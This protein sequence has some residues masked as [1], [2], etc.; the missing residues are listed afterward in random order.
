MSKMV[1]RSALA[2]GVTWVVNT[3][4]VTVEG[5]GGVTDH[6]ALTGLADDDHPQYAR[7]AQNLA[8]LASAATAR[9]NLGLGTAAVAAA[10]DFDA[11]GAAAAAQAAAIA[12][13]QPVDSDLTAISVLTTTS[14]GRSL[15]TQAD[16]PAARST[17]GV[18]RVVGGQDVGPRVEN[19]N[20]ETRI[21]DGTI[22]L[23]ALAAGE[24]VMFRGA[25]L[26]LNNSG[27]TR[28]VTLRLKVGATTLCRVVSGTLGSS[29]VARSG[30]IDGY[31][32]ANGNNDADGEMTA[33]VTNTSD[34]TNTLG[35]EMTVNGT[36]TEAIQTAGLAFDLTAQLAI[37]NATQWIELQSFALWRIAA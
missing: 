13:S 33:L 8:D 23:P 22:S 17:L 24:L 37:G 29:A 6:G 5:G 18:G 2:P 7:K 26:W 34:P 27:A 19:T 31:I 12:A 32:R 16:A 21:L 1:W 28:T 9:T 3:G 36:M 11:A 15:L 10:T 35:T 14:Y 25:F 20:V 4:P 30:R